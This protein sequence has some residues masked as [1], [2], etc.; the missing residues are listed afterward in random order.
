MSISPPGNKT[1]PYNL[2]GG[3]GG[4]AHEHYV[5]HFPSDSF[6]FYETLDHGCHGL[7]STPA[8]SFIGGLI[9]NEKPSE[10]LEMSVNLPDN[11]YI[12]QGSS[13]SSQKHGVEKYN[14]K[15]L[16]QREIVKVPSENMIKLSKVS[17][18]EPYRGTSRMVQFLSSCKT[19]AVEYLASL[20]SYKSTL[21]SEITVCR[22][23]STAAVSAPVMPLPLTRRFSMEYSGELNLS[24]CG[25]RHRALKGGEL[26]ASINVLSDG[27]GDRFVDQMADK[28]CDSDNKG[29]GM[30]N[31]HEPCGILNGLF[32]PGSKRLF[33]AFN[34]S[35]F[36][37][38][39]GLLGM[40]LLVMFFMLNAC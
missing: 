12:Q 33:V 25:L 21:V 35:S 3:G 1:Q 2:P 16:Q 27:D 9:L 14:Q 22:D 36:A 8:K 6:Q 4:L 37:L 7:L 23:I 19:K 38:I 13:V 24:T 17:V 18:H 40:L 10:V 20:K 28:L 39:C 30:I 31:L 15:H 32:H 26:S 5:D 11:D 34:G 29:I